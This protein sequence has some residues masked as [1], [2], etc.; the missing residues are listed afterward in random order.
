M[1]LKKLVK[2]E[3]YL[4][5]QIHL[6]GEF[7]SPE[8]PKYIPAERP[9]QVRH[10]DNLKMTGDFITVERTEF[11]PAERPQQVRPEDNLRPEGLFYQPEKS[12]PVGKNI[13]LIDSRISQIEK[14]SKNNA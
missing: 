2:R 10:E 4:F 1:Q 8:K 9:R 12:Q 11:I 13:L 7:Y 3:F 6:E 14:K 5:K